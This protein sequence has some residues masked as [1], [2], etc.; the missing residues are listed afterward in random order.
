M[1]LIKQSNSVYNTLILRVRL[2]SEIINLS[3]LI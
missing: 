3:K 1:K 2:F